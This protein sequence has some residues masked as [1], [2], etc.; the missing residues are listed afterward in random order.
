[1]F[2]VWHDELGVFEG[3]FAG[4]VLEFPYLMEGLS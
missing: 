3:R 1:M 2:A 4:C